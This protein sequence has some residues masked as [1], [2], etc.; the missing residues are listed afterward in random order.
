[1]IIQRYHFYFVQPNLD[2]EFP[3]IFIQWGG[4]IVCVENT[5][6]RRGKRYMLWA[7]YIRDSFL[8]MVASLRKIFILFWDMGFKMANMAFKMVN[9]G[10]KMV[11]MADK[12]Q[13]M[14]FEME[15]K[16]FKMANMAFKIQDMVVKMEDIGAEKV[17][18]C[19]NCTEL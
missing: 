19:R 5:E 18:N 6:V 10:F 16:G 7:I 8:K 2:W 4:L 11:N 3:Y 9:M 15:D 1:M 14:G 13:D 17:S 12:I